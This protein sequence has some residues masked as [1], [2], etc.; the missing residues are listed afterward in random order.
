MKN[1]EPPNL[2]QSFSDLSCENPSTAITRSA[3]HAK[4]QIVDA[5][6]GTTIALHRFRYRTISLFG[7]FTDEL[8]CFH[9]LAER[10]RPGTRY[11][12]RP[13]SSG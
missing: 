11:R 7:E 5:D 1:R 13:S 2:P 12:E 10:R 8:G 6:L 4:I 3:M 9:F